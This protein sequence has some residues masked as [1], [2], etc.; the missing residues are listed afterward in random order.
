[1]K[2]GQRGALGHHSPTV[3]TQRQHFLS[4][5]SFPDCSKASSLERMLVIILPKFSFVSWACGLG[6]SSHQHFES[7]TQEVIPF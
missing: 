6:K 2:R 1:M 5:K 7:L 3:L 4:R